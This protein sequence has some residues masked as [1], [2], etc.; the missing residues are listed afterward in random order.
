[1]IMQIVTVMSSI[2]IVNLNC[3]SNILLSRRPHSLMYRQL[4]EHIPIKSGL[5]GQLPVEAT[6]YK[7]YRN[8][9]NDSGTAT[10]LNAEPV[11]ASPYDDT[12]AIEGTSYY[13]WV[14]AHNDGGDSSFSNPD[15]GWRTLPL[16]G[17]E[18]PY[19]P[20]LWNDGDV[21]QFGTNCYAYSLNN[22]V[23]PGTNELCYLQPGELAEHDPLPLSAFQEE[24][25]ETQ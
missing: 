12:S 11:S 14:K 21:I 7:V 23:Y 10:L 5:A 25:G 1:M 22:Q 6:G 20:S 3:T 15:T 9:A 13:Y 4:M 18:V 17:D 19:E 16:S 24:D 8:T 2:M